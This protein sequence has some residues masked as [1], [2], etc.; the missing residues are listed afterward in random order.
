MIPAHATIRSAEPVEC[1]ALSDLALRSKGYWGY[2]RD[3]LE[4]CREELTVDPADVDRLRVTVAEEDGEP[5]GFYAIGGEPPEG[6]I[7]FFFVAPERIG[8]GIGRALWRHCVVTAT[9][10]GLSR[11][12]IESD[13]NALGFYLSRGA[14]QVGETPSQSIPGRSN[15]LLSLDVENARLD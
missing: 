5:V 13:P 10:I 14:V 9:R 3:F 12:R 11:I 7:W 8:T 6:E 4:A 15:P 1:G 2:D